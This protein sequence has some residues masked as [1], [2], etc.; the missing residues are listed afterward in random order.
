MLVTCFYI[1]GQCRDSPPHPRHQ[2]PPLNLAVTQVMAVKHWMNGHEVAIDRA[3]PKDEPSALRTMFARLPMGDTQ[4][5]SFDNGASFIAPNHSHATDTT[6]SHG[7]K[8]MVE[9]RK[10]C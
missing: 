1:A 5:R 4:R 10:E 2:S 7:T 3:T 9:D 6:T 8:C